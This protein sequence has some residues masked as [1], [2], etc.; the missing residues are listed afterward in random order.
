MSELKKRVLLLGGSFNPIHE[1]GHVKLCLHIFTVLNNSGEKVDEVWLMPAAQN[2][3]KSLDE[4]VEYEHRLQMCKIQ[5][6]PY[7]DWLKVSDF[8]STISAPHYTHRVLSE[9]V[10]AYPDHEFAWIMGSDNLA[11]FHKWEYWEDILKM[12]PVVVSGRRCSNDAA[13][14]SVTLD[15]YPEALHASQ[16]L[17]S[18]LPQ[19]H[20]FE[21]NLEGRATDIRQA[22]ALGLDA[23]E[24]C[25]KV[26]D[27]IE[28]HGL[29]R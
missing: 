20:M 16:S 17:F 7:S 15:T 9:L 8:E 24:L 13:I 29:Y 5:A 23:P 10:N 1:E 19:I 28:M 11:G 27:Y 4:M 26:R 2:P 25:Y 3:E 22:V 6:E 14:N 12:M 21:M 18:E